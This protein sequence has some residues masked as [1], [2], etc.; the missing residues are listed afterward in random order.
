MSRRSRFALATLA[1]TVTA[2]LAFVAPAAA[3]PAVVDVTVAESLPVSRPGQV[4]ANSGLDCDTPNRVRTTSATRSDAGGIATFSGTKVFDCRGRDRLIVDFE[5]SVDVGS[6]ADTAVGTWT[7][8]GGRGTYA[9]AIGGGDLIGTYVD[10]DACT[11]S[12][13]DDRYTGAVLLATP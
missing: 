5:V 3:L 9:G 2:G 6:C 1:G 10:G 11:N 8:T 4:V 13:I 7:V 12:G